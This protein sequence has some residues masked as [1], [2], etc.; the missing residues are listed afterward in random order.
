MRRYELPMALPLLRHVAG[1]VTTITAE[2][3]A[4]VTANATSPSTAT[5]N[6]ANATTGATTGAAAG[7]AATKAEAAEPGVTSATPAS[8]AVNAAGNATD[9]TSASA[10]AASANA[11]RAKC[12]AAS[13]SAPI[14][15]EDGSDAVGE[16]GDVSLHPSC[17]LPIR[18]DLFQ[19]GC[20]N[21]FP[22]EPPAC[23]YGLRTA[24]YVSQMAAV[25]RPR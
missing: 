10:R 13:A 20:V 19:H 21:R 18:H 23:S 8:A 15:P 12:E 22:L 17:L 5:A 4:A 2:P 14:A 25:G 24:P 1:G 7:A 16:G 9:N 6:A 11:A 3:A